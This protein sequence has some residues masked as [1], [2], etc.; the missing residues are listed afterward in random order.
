MSPRKLRMAVPAVAVRSRVS[1]T[2]AA[3]RKL[4]RRLPEAAITPVCLPGSICAVSPPRKTQCRDKPENHAGEQREPNRERQYGSVDPNKDSAGKESG[5]SA[6]GSF[7]SQYDAATRRAAP[8]NE[9]TMASTSNWRTI[10]QR[11]AP[12]A[13]RIASSCWRVRPRASRR[14]EQLAQPMIRRSTTHPARRSFSVCAGVLLVKVQMIGFSSVCKSLG[15][16][17][18]LFPRSRTRGSIAR[19]RRQCDVGPELD[20]RYVGEAE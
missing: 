20:P 19:W 8:V 7:A 9:M 2:C 16:L 18:V 11:L 6:M 13:L 12:M 4:Q 15:P 1:A 3:M 5:E 14:M 17:R 10:R